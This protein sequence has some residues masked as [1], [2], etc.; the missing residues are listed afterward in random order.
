[1]SEGWCGRGDSNPHALAGASPSRGPADGPS[2]SVFLENSRVW[3]LGLVRR[4]SQECPDF[5]GILAC[6]Q[7]SP[8]VFPTAYARVSTGVFGGRI[9]NGALSP[10]TTRCPNAVRSGPLLAGIAAGRIGRRRR[11]WTDGAPSSAG[12]SVLAIQQLDELA[13]G[14]ARRKNPNSGREL[15]WF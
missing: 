3:T 11:R 14:G 1:V 9:H 5:L 10:N 7:T 2:R 12:T 15:G 13:R 4:R 8:T 6:A